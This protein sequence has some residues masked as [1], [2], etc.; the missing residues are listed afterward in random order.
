VDYWS[1]ADSPTFNQGDPRTS[2]IEK[3]SGVGIYE[4][5]TQQVIDRQ[6]KSMQSFLLRTSL[7]EEFGRC[8]L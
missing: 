6:S 3:V 5:L 2:R 8:S 7:L 1:A 4:Y